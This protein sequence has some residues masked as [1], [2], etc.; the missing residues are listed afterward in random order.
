[1]ELKERHKGLVA[2]VGGKT[3]V[4]LLLE[5]DV[6]WLELRLMS[7]AMALACLVIH[8][9][10][11]ATHTK[12]LRQAYQADYIF[13]QL[14]K[15][16]PDFFPKP[17]KQTLR[18]S[19]ANRVALLEPLE[20][21][22]L[23]KE[24]LIKLYVESYDHLH[25]GKI[26]TLT[27]NMSPY[28]FNRKKVAEYVRLWARLLLVHTIQPIDADQVYLVRMGAASTGSVDV[29]PFKAGSSFPADQFEVKFPLDP[30]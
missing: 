15:L 22:Y 27:T 17:W 4:G 30:K 20:E 9:D 24:L 2:V 25:R 3:N 16:H 23:T 19:R 14:G 13:K 5:R 7:E 10:I 12:P 8:G 21:P 26:E 28:Q 6:S 1:M 18:G 29:Q 11:G